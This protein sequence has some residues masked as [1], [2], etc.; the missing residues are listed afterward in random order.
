MDHDDETVEGMLEMILQEK[1]YL[2]TPGQENYKDFGEREIERIENEYKNL[3]GSLDPLKEMKERLLALRK[4]LKECKNI[5]NHNKTRINT[6]AAKRRTKL[7][8]EINDLSQ[9]INEF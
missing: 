9:V 4:Q 3:T 7:R 5:K 1:G 8:K 6:A 2:D